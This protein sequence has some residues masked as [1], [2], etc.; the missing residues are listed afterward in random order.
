MSFEFGFPADAFYLFKS[1]GL[2]GGA[3]SAG[4]GLLFCLGMAAIAIASAL[5]FGAIFGFE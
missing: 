2:K 3:R 4:L 1:R 5:V